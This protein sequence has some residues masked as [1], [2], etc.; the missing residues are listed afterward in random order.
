M[1]GGRL[2]LGID[3]GTQSTKALV[4]DEGSGRVIARAQ[5]PYG[6]L[7]SLPPGHCEQHPELWIAA[8]QQTAAS[9]LSQV[10]KDRV[11]GVGVSGQQHGC[12]LLDAHAE[13]LR[14]AK[15]WC[16][17]ATAAEAAELSATLA[18]PVPTGFTDR[19]SDR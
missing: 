4:L 5:E 18:R 7:P 17:T 6:L 19:P 9:A 11:A 2:F 16:D 13:V 14:P 8:V 1:G 15:L 10:D 3:V 12:V